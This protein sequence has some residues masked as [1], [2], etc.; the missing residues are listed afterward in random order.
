MLRESIS[1]IAFFVEHPVCSSF[2]I[3]AVVIL[4]L[5]L[6]LLLLLFYFV[7]QQFNQREC[8]KVTFFEIP[9]APRKTQCYCIFSG[10]LCM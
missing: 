2:K 6:L 5:L 9:G 3:Y 7:L 1:A 10:T 4:L 8:V